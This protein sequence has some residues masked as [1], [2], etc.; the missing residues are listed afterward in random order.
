MK[1]FESEVTRDLDRWD[2]KRG[3]SDFS[4]LK[5]LCVV[6]EKKIKLSF[7]I[8]NNKEVTLQTHKHSSF[9]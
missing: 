1:R 3:P 7:N 6:L 4:R 2:S 9:P 5:G 8:Y